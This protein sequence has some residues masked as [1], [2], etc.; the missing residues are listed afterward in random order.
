MGKTIA[1]LGYLECP[2]VAWLKE[3]EE[4]VIC[5]TE[6]IG[7]EYIDRYNIEFVISYGYRHIIKKDLLDRLPDR[8]IN[9][10]VSYL[11][12]NR[13]ADPNL[14]S[15]I[16]NTPCGVTI[17]Y[18]DEGVDTGD[19]I[20]QKLVKFE[21]S[22]EQPLTLESTYWHLRGEIEDLFKQYWQQ[23]RTGD[24]P[25]KKQVGEG[26]FHT[27]KQGNAVFRKL[28]RGISIKDLQKFTADE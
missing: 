6:P 9:L 4:E 1:F 18:V 15:W 22:G 25:R 8:V 12:W 24:C 11:P 23:I 10:H 19:V 2:L 16:E 28:G 5:C 17:H 7:P 26:S 14:W 21:E 3:K 13:G 27:V 20:V